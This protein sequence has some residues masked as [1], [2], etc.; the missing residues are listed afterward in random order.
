M[1]FDRIYGAWWDRVIRTDAQGAVRR[2]VERYVRAQTSATERLS[3]GDELLAGPTIT[4][5]SGPSAGAE[6]SSAP[7]PVSSASIRRA[8][9]ELGERDLGRA[10]RARR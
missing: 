5:A 7:A 9:A 6:P 4:A 1:A 10:R 2:G 8:G 3:G